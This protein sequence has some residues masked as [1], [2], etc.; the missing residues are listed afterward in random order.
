MILRE[1]SGLAKVVDPLA[2]SY[3]V[4]SLTASLI[5]E[6][7]KLIGE[8]ESLGGMTKAVEAGMPK[9]RIEESAARRQ[10]RLD[11]GEEIIVGV[12]RFASD[13]EDEVDLLEVDNQ[14][15]RQSQIERLH[16]VQQ[17]RD[18]V[19]CQDA[20]EKLRCRAESGEWGLLQ[21]SIEAARERATVGEI[22]DS[23][24]QVFGQHRALP[25]AISGVYRTEI[26]NLD[27]VTQFGKKS[28]RLW[29]F[30]IAAHGH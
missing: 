14:A 30:T 12:N 10:A 8:V 29:M 16:Q 18:Q 7:K 6:S 5:A 21:L 27:E 22:T 1:E 13:D 4:E 23:L 24:R 11:M 26:S 3:Y 2:G 20:L 17:N 15:V 19:R 9:R 25:Q 28:I